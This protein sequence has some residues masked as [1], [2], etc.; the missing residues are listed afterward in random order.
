MGAKPSHPPWTPAESKAFLIRIFEE[1]NGKPLPNRT[2][3][4]CEQHL[5]DI[6]NFCLPRIYKAVHAYHKRNRQSTFSK[7]NTRS[8]LSNPLQDHD[9]KHYYDVLSEIFK[10]DGNLIE[11]GV[12]DIVEEYYAERAVVQQHV[13]SAEV[14]NQP[15][16][17][18]SL[19]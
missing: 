13:G 18:T 5:N 16:D 1:R 4:E 15:V 12:Y 10:L 11:Q 17:I 8:I 19:P 7:E 3:Q 14:G 6:L 9:E 2:K